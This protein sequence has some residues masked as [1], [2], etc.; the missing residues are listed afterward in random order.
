MFLYDVY[1]TQYRSYKIVC[2]TRIYL[3]QGLKHR[4]SIYSLIRFVEISPADFY[5]KDRPYII[6]HHIIIFM[7]RLNEFYYKNILQ[8]P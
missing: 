2:R 7:K 5:D 1:V 8:K 6:P 3:Q 4:K